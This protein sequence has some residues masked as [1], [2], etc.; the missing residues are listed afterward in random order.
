MPNLDARNVNFN[1]VI[2]GIWH[3]LCEYYKAPKRLPNPNEGI[4]SLCDDSF[5]IHNG[6]CKYCEAPKDFQT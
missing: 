1:Y 6:W 5:S 3:I 4:T 2:Y